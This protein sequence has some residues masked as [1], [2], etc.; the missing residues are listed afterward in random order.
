MAT[1]CLDLATSAETSPPGFEV[2]AE[3]RTRVL[4]LCKMLADATRLRI[5]YYLT[6]EAE[7][8]VSQLCRRIGQ[9]Q[10]AVSHHLAM[11][12]A[13]GIVDHRRHGRQ[14]FYSIQGESLRRTLTQLFANP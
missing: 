5:C 13:N 4:A 6:N 1:A 10:P 7:L 9:S 2:P 14:I 11:M 3:V 12:R 8:N